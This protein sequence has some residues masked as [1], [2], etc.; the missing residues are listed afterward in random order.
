M[1]S[2]KR[3]SGELPS[4]AARQ[5]RASSRWA[6]LTLQAVPVLLVVVFA[7]TVLLFFPFRFAFELDPDEGIQ[8]MKALLHAG[9]K[10]LYGQIYSDQPP[11]FTVLLSG[12]VHVFGA[13]VLPARL[14]VL[15]FSLVSLA[16]AA[17]HLRRTWGW[18]HGAAAVVLM[19]L[20]PAYIQLSVS[21]MVGLPAISL[22]MLSLLS[23]TVWHERSRPLLL[24]LAA[25]L[26]AVS[27]MVKLFTVVL[28][29]AVLVGVLAIPAGESDPAGRRFGALRWKAAGLWAAVF[30]GVLSVLV[31][32][33]VGPTHLGQLV[34]THLGVQGI[35]YFA[36]ETLMRHT[37]DLWPL[38][39]LAAI[40]VGI[41]IHR[42]VWT[43]LYYAAW[44]VLAGVLLAVNTPVWYHQQLLVAIPASVLAGIGLVEPAHLALR[45]QRGRWG[46]GL[47]ALAAAGLAAMYV[48]WAGPRFLGKLRADMP[49]L[50]AGA[51]MD[52][53]EY[54]LL[55]LIEYFDPGGSLLI[56]DRPMF[57]F[58]SRRDLPPGMANLS[59]KV[60]RS[61][62]VTEGQ[63]IEII[64]ESEAPV[65][66][67]GRFD[68]PEVEAYLKPGYD[69][70]YGYVDLRLFV[71]P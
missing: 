60:L 26:L 6:Q 55:T 57:A 1:A 54:D 32:G 25:A 12:L 52:A 19:A 68:L 56:T 35:A 8:L 47:L 63:I 58:R 36:G 62:V 22:A 59:Q 70:V 4:G 45:G 33:W 40:G 34:E 3:V 27:T 28:V 20:I 69:Q 13:K 21:V 42:K 29:P 46:L 16:S 30:V 44:V 2:E 37:R 7:L 51:A 18:T 11:L 67:L 24:I 10:S 15:G 49:N 31:L 53:R 39:L 5:S 50:V 38:F 64:R 66:L 17:E 14:A 23:L 43:S 61:G 71:R 65:V 41:S 9:G 48:I